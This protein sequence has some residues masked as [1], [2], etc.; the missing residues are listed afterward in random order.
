MDIWADYKGR[1]GDCGNK[2]EVC[3]CADLR[4]APQAYDGQEFD[5]F[6]EGNY[7]SPGTYALDKNDKR[8]K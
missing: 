4:S 6:T 7:H 2:L 1:C 8:G 3:R 5:T